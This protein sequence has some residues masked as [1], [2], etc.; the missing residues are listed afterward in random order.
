M[1]P[2]SMFP[3]NPQLSPPDLRARSK[4]VFGNADRLQVGAAVAR[5]SSGVVHAQE[6]ATQLG[7]APPRVRTQ[8]LAFVA[9]GLMEPLPR[10]G[11]TVDYERIEDPFWDLLARIED[12]WS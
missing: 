3:S 7:I 1:L 6:L 9:A 8:L 2:D 10:A 12:A 5:S 11:A 4:L